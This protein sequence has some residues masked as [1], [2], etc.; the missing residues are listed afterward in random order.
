VTDVFVVDDDPDIRALLQIALERD[1]HRV[2]A[3]PNGTA[4]LAALRERRAGPPV[5][6]LDVQMPDLD[7]WQVLG[8]IRRDDSLRDLA[9]IL[10]TVKASP[11]DLE[12]GWRTGCD[13][14]LTKPFDISAISNEV[15]SLA[16]LTADERRARR[17]AR[18]PGL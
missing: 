12:R 6:I 9:V 13:A 16:S 3:A 15:S 14:Y 8:E 1:G 5:V 4:G 7:G 11:D 2:D 10:C 17:D 18:R